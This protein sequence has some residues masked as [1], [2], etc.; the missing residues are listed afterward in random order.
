MEVFRSMVEYYWWWMYTRKSPERANFSGFYIFLKMVI[1]F[2]NPYSKCNIFK[3]KILKIISYHG[4]KLIIRTVRRM[5]R[6]YV[7]ILIYS[8]ETKT[9]LN[10]F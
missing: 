7:G 5:K 6:A 4:N 1:L 10:I 3:I 9:N 8:V 2:N